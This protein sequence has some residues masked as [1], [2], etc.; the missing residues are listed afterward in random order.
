MVT[1]LKLGPDSG[2]EDNSELPVRVLRRSGAASRERGRPGH[3]PSQ[4]KWLTV[5]VLEN[6]GRNHIL[7]SCPEW[8]GYSD[9]CG[10]TTVPQAGPFPA[11]AGCCVFLTAATGHVLTG[12][13]G[14]PRYQAYDS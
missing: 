11:A 13:A 2:E 5:C 4:F 1:L 8:Q 7:P 9:K 6:N 10:K 3:F 12:G 14:N